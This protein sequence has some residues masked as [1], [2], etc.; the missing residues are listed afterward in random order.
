MGDN[1]DNI[2]GIPGWGEKTAIKALKKHGSLD[3][4]LEAYKAKY[5]DARK[6]HSDL[7]T[8]E[9]G[10]DL[11]KYLYEK[12]SKK[13]RFVYPD[14]SFDMPY[15]GVLLA[16]DQG[17]VTGSKSEIMALLFESRVKLAYSLK[18]MDD[19]IPELPEF[20]KGVMNTDKLGEYFDFFDIR[21]LE[22]AMSLF[23]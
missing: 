14:I 1:G 22:T 19:D 23:E 3:K 13:D 11:F 15:T 5:E 10:K 20:S 2:F 4:V 18:K 6:A 17:F 9:D 7:N 21:T 8:R 16:F 12:K